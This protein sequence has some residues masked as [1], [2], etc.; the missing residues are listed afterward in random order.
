MSCQGL[1]V[2]YFVTPFA[3]G[4]DFSTVHLD[5]D[6]I[7]DIVKLL[8]GPMEGLSY[9]H[10]QGYIH[11]DVTCRNMF[12][13]ADGS[14]VL[15]DYGKILKE[16]A[17]KSNRTGPAHTRAP[18]IDGIGLYDNS[19][20][21]WS[22][23]FAIMKILFQDLYFW[24]TFNN[25]GPQSKAWTEEGLRNLKLLA[26]RSPLHYDVANTVRRMIAYEAHHRPTMEAVLARWSALDLTEA[27]TS[28]D[29]GNNGPPAKFQKTSEN[30][31]AARAAPSLLGRE[32]AAA[33]LSMVDPSTG[34]TIFQQGQKQYR[35]ALGNNYPLAML[36]QTYE[37]AGVAFF[38]PSSLGHVPPAANPPMVDPSPGV[39]IFQQNQKQNRPVPSPL[40]HAPPNSSMVDPSTGVT[41]F[42]Q[43]QKQYREDL[44]NKDFSDMVQKAFDDAMR[45]RPAPPP[46]GRAPPAANPSMVQL[47]PSVNSSMVQLPPTANR[48]MVQLPPAANPSV[49]KPPP[50]TSPS[51]VES[52]AELEI[53]ETGPKQNDQ[54]VNTGNGGQGFAGLTEAQRQY[55][56]NPKPKTD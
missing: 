20:D 53:I 38:A 18:E 27:A 15:G 37:N 14:G 28:A 45:T 6:N 12:I 5:Q 40:G 46:L 25:N 22:F 31:K 17:T 7:R 8:R 16:V 35:E 32:A 44:S 41:I 52:S 21:V 10:D 42:Q 19:A 2:F 30:T 34:V 29:L 54:A 51:V 1:D 23:G 43:G 3:S 55:L 26:R 47:A 4:G 24:V 9:L 39:A 56:A 33:N 36:Q 11:C 48:S 50:A 13:M 49:I